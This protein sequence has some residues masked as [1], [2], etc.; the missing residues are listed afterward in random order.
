VVDGAVHI[1][2]TVFYIHCLGWFSSLR[3]L[4]RLEL[5]APRVIPTLPH[6]PPRPPVG[7]P[8]AGGRLIFD[9]K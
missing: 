5:L 6:L 2:V 7:I 3:A 4:K 1:N 9:A 8:I